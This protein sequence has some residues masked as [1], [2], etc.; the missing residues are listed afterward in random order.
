VNLST[1]V[2]A[3]AQRGALR[4]VVVATF[5]SRSVP[6]V[7]GGAANPALSTSVPLWP[8][9]GGCDAAGDTAL[10]KAVD[11][12]RRL[13][14][15]SSVRR[16]LNPERW[17][18]E[19]EPVVREHVAAALARIGTSAPPMALRTDVQMTEPS[20]AYLGYLRFD[21]D[22]DPAPRI[23]WVR[24]FAPLAVQ[25]YWRKFDSEDLVAGT[26]APVAES[27][28]AQLPD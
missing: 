9:A 4:S 22:V 21:A 17:P 5:N 6:T 18:S 23:A 7:A 8:G 2:L 13:R 15:C 16:T 26:A 14:V 11:T 25:G 27:P 19:L 20:Q 28:F 10:H 12:S 1:V 3:R 24:G